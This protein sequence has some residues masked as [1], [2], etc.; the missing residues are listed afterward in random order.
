M[1]GRV[2][3]LTGGFFTRLTLVQELMHWEELK[4][5]LS[6]PFMAKFDLQISKGALL[7]CSNSVV[8]RR[9]QA[10]KQLM[11]ENHRP[12]PCRTSPC[13]ALPS[14]QNKALAGTKATWA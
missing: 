11:L 9:I 4:S 1:L 8:G 3:A 7:I 6:I 5:I 12:K 2:R 10:L 13:L 14:F